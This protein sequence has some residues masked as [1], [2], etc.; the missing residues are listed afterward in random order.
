MLN[1]KKTL[2]AFQKLKIL[3]IGD[4]MVDSYL[5]G[6]VD[7][8]SPEA[9]V[10][11]VKLSHKEDRPG[12]AANVALNIKSLGATPFLCSVVGK[13]AAGKK[14]VELL[15]SHD[16]STKYLFTSDY[17]RTTLKT[18]IIAQNQQML[19]FD[20]EDTQ[21]LLPEESKELVSAVKLL[22]DE[23]EIDAIIF[24]DYNKGVLSNLMIR[25][26]FLAAIRN[27][28]PTIVDPKNKNFFSYKRATLFK[29]NLKEINDN[30]PFKSKP[31]LLDIKKAADQIEHELHNSMTLITLS[32]KGIFYSHKG[33]QNIVPTKPRNIADVC[34]AGDSVVSVAACCVALGL[35]LRDI[36]E[37]ANLAGGQVCEKVGVVPVSAKE[38]GEDYLK[39]VVE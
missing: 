20:E 22:L 23:S 27:D 16:I 6:D 30:L 7:R 25:E 12:G 33:E 36:A 1:I 14:L 39:L 11:I 13:D 21:D 19:R 10:P 34:G 5:T 24:Q 18:R 35:P 32:D 4:V 37:L 26:I 38:L 17:R 9:P 31:N 8:I 29:P 2:S 3:I 28:V 15:P